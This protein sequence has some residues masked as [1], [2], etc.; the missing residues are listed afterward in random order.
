MNDSN[1]MVESELVKVGSY[2]WEVPYLIFDPGDI[3]KHP[4][5]FNT[6]QL[7]K[8]EWVF[9]TIK[10]GRTPEIVTKVD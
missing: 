4:M 2:S 6:G 9:N 8:R 5:T 10:I 1:R 7:Y 3:T